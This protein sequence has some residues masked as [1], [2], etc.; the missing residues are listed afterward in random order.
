MIDSATFDVQELLRNTEENF[1][2]DT[3]RMDEL[4]ERVEQFEVYIIMKCIFDQF[5]WDHHAFDV[6]YFGTHYNLNNCVPVICI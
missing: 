5:F 2:G 3:K 6:L 4:E 1:E